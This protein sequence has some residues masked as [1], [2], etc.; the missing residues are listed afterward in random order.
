M[1]TQKQ[2]KI[3][4]TS[5]ER[6]GLSRDFKADI[7]EFIWNGF[8]AKATIVEI[9][10]KVNAIEGI[11]EISITDNG[12]GIDFD[13]IEETFGI[14]LDSKKSSIAGSSSYVHGKKG[15]GRF[16]FQYFAT[17]AEWISVYEKNGKK[18]K[19]KIEIDADNKEQFSLSEPEEIRNDTHGTGCIVRFYQLNEAVVQ[20]VSPSFLDFLKFEFGWFLHLNKSRGYKLLV[21]GLK[22]EY[23]TIISDSDQRTVE[24]TVG[25]ESYKFDL[26]F[27]EWKNNIG[28]DYYFIT[29]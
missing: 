25:K 11:E 27:I 1:S 2:V 18:Y 7:A 17:S 4:N 19:F 24:I 12:E 15:I 23:E 9:N 20:L 10:Y 16:S 14:L 6:A 13:T 28:D 26:N 3:N 29:F 8:D 21:N 22:L 5:V